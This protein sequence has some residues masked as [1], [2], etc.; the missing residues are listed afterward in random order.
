[1][2]AN[3]DGCLAMQVFYRGGRGDAELAEAA[4]SYTYSCAPLPLPPSLHLRT[5]EPD[6]SVPGGRLLDGALRW[7]CLMV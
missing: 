3:L 6:W 5:D 4:G 2:C 7:D 1:M